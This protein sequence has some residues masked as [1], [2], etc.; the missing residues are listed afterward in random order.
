MTV[1]TRYRARSPGRPA[2]QAPRQ[3]RGNQRQTRHGPLVRLQGGHRRGFL[4]HDRLPHDI[5]AAGG[6]DRPLADQV[7]PAHGLGSEIGQRLAMGGDRLRR[8]A[9]GLGEQGG[10]EG[11]N[12]IGG[13]GG[14]RR[15]EGF[16][17]L[18]CAYTPFDT[19][20]TVDKTPL[21]GTHP[22]TCVNR[23]NCV[24]GG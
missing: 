5:L 18:F 24:T 12:L 9:L 4:G 15:R 19:I 11:F 10:G 23:V 16:R 2:H 13:G 20:D 6:V 1:S 8:A 14:E 17:R 3:G 21:A 22:P 7:E